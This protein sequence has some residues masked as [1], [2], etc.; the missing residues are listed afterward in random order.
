MM[1]DGIRH[2]R[3]VDLSVL[4]AARWA[5]EARETPR[6]R[7]PEVVRAWRRTYY[8]KHRKMI[9]EGVRRAREKRGIKPFPKP[10]VKD[11]LPAALVILRDWPDRPMTGRELQSLTGLS[12][13]AV[14][15]SLMRAMRAGMVEVVSV[16]YRR[17]PG[18]RRRR[19]IEAKRYSPTAE[20]R[21]VA[22]WAV[23]LSG[24]GLLG[25]G[26]PRTAAASHLEPVRYWIRGLDVPS[27]AIG[28][29]GVR[30]RSFRGYL[31]GEL[32]DEEWPDF[33][34]CQA[35][36]PPLESELPED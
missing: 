15:V 23:W 21:V 34:E 12:W 1:R 17:T 5:Q 4:S 36:L 19:M 7:S 22:C 28:R 26:L 10:E 6:K 3:G 32:E 29:R 9:Q 14:R 16:A 13:Q 30:G 2:L 27:R 18:D 33:W 35:L 24:R 11:V 31:P 20:G 25:W 8:V